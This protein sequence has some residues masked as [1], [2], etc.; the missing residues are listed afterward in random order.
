MK[1]WVGWTKQSFYSRTTKTRVSVLVRES[2]RHHE[3]VNEGLVLNRIVT[4]S[5]CRLFATR[6]IAASHQILARIFMIVLLP[7]HRPAAAVSCRV[8]EREVVRAPFDHQD[9]EKHDHQHTSE[10]GSES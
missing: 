8:C 7:L 2:T 3:L 5:G 6:A 1:R 10:V 9:E 4:E